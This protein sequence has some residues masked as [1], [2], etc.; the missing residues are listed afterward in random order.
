MKSTT[1]SIAAAV[2]GASSALA[3]VTPIQPRQSSLP[4]VEV[5]GNGWFIT[6][7]FARTL[8][9]WDQLSS[10]VTLVSTFEV[11]TTNLVARQKLS[12]L[13]PISKPAS[14]MLPSSRNWGSTPSAST[15]S[16]IQRTM[17][18]A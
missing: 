17:M 8:T 15:Q 16:T 5:K 12:I 2:A 3:G 10:P 14:E 6:W 1:L 4:A 7:G 9:D 11:L 18:S 13:L